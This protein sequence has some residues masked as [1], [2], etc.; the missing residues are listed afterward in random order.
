MKSDGTGELGASGGRSD[1][2]PRGK[3]SPM[4]ETGTD[5]VPTASRRSFLAA[6]GVTAAAA[7]LAGCTTADPGLPA[8]S[9]PARPAAPDAGVP[10]GTAAPI[11]LPAGTPVPATGDRQ[12]GV[13][14]PQP[15]QPHLLIIV[16]D[17]NSAPGPL[18]AVLG[19]EIIALTAGSAPAT[20]GIDPGDLTVT[21]GVGPSLVAAVGPDLPGAT[22]LP[23]FA[24]EQL[25]DRSDGGDLMVQICATDPLLLPLV[26][27]AI[28][29]SGGTDLVERWRQR[30]FRGPY[31]PIDA[32]VAAPRNVL[33]FVDG[34][35][36]PHTE[37]QWD[38]DVWLTA[39]P[40]VAGG[41]IAVIRRMR[42]D[43][44]AF[45]RLSVAAQESVVGRERATSAPLSGGTAAS[46][47]DL[48]AKT[49][50]GRY[51]IPVDAH[52]RRAHSLAAGVPMML[53]RSYSTDDPAA[54]L[55]FVS[56]QDD[57]QT[58]T[59]TMARLDAADALL[60]FTTT[61]ATGA[62]LVLPGFGPATPLGATVF[63]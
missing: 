39:P 10:A 34:I 35:V 12:A 47:P 57:L 24:R 49:P 30:G 16:Y 3:I 15:P 25:A 53:R 52:V 51:R 11:P 60:D 20:A 62:F 44:D 40:A 8:A 13:T 37:A 26:A 9:G 19:D 17:L 21:V 31:V 5:G 32:T 36:G 18:L 48:G 56:F 63:G 43:V 23:S 61:T 58:F 54:G 27:A 6:A 7:A 41:T 28:A 50:D 42:I 1:D 14:T 2:R 29:A 33:G 45:H 22:T 4:N 59:R 46:E 55:L 38:A